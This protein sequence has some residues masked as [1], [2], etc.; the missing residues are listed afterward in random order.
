M[1]LLLPA[2]NE[3]VQEGSFGRISSFDR[4]AQAERIGQE[5]VQLTGGTRPLTF[6]FAE[7]ETERYLRP[8]QD[9]V[10]R[11]VFLGAY[12]DGSSANFRFVVQ[13]RQNAD[14]EV[15]VVMIVSNHT[16][17]RGRVYMSAEAREP[18]LLGGA[19]NC[20]ATLQIVVEQLVFALSTRGS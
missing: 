15:I 9:L 4:S 14:A 3:L 1:T 20:T 8:M 7:G 2:C 11:M 13:T 5:L 18:C 16:S 17:D 10:S 6:T 19:T 12:V